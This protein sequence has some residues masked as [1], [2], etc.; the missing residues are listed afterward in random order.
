MKK[1][2][3]S[4]AIEGI[5]C[6]Y[7]EE[8]VDFEAKRSRHLKWYVGT[9]ACLVLVA[10]SFLAVLWH[11]NRNEGKPVRPGALDPSGLISLGELERYYKDDVRIVKETEA[12]LLP[13]ECLSIHQ[14]YTSVIWEGCHYDGG[15][16]VELT[17]D[18][19][20]R[21][22]G[23]LDAEGYDLYQEVLHRKSFVA[24]EIEGL[25]P[26]YCI[27]LKMDGEFYKYR[28]RNYTFPATLGELLEECR[29]DEMFE[30]NYHSIY[31]DGQREGTYAIAD[32][33]PIWEII[34]SCADVPCTSEGFGAIRG[35]ALCFTMTSS[36]FG[37]YKLS[38]Y[39]TE[40]GYL[41]TNVFDYALVCN[42]GRD[43]AKRIMDYT[44]KNAEPTKDLP[45][46]SA[47][48]GK[49][50]EIG[51]DYMLVSDS[52][53]C[54]D[55][56]DGITFKVWLSTPALQHMVHKWHGY[57]VGSMVRV[58]FREDLTVDNG[59]EIRNPRE[60][61]RVFLVRDDVMIPEASPEVGANETITI[62]SASD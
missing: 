57:S 24:Y 49:V 4:E 42:I 7:V 33:D 17:K 50:T 51:E 27:A 56:A 25:S 29:I 3:L 30:L 43:A 52:I 2:F 10:A 20:G 61:E 5:D 54:Q 46:E 48:V 60:I 13:W 6:R 11:M 38:L 28:N 34:K 62:T 14:Q 55:P 45:Y 1:E 18:D 19:I 8:A 39:V 23:E 37:A 32:D 53:L 21:K 26:E 9:A 59:Y 22:I 31:R 12:V 44:K 16:A 41:K 47:I 15:V 35:E 40:D 36:K 58:S